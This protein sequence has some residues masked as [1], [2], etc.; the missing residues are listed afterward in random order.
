MT[1]MEWMRKFADNLNKLMF[2]A[3]I[4]QKELAIETGVTVPTI[5]RYL[6]AQRIPCGKSLVNM[7]LALN[8]S[9]D[10]LADFGERIK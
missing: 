1:E 7:S 9:I 10:E 5:S 3:N 2:D 4:S 8:C 6:N